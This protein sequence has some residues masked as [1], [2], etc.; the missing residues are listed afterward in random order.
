VGLRGRTSLS[1][2]PSTPQSY[3][4]ALGIRCLTLETDSPVP[5]P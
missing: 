5:A 3:H 4:K 2:L 1:L